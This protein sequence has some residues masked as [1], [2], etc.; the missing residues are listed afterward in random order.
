MVCIACGAFND[1]Y[2]V[3]GNTRGS[4]HMPLM[5]VKLNST[6]SLNYAIQI[7]TM[8]SKYYQSF[9]Q[10]RNKIT[11]YFQNKTFQSE[12]DK[13]SGWKEELENLC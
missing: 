13:L 4:H 5:P 6:S 11:E 8:L 2:Y 9:T 1:P 7:I 3:A 12:Y 10:F